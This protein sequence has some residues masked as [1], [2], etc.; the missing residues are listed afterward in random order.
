M[1]EELKKYKEI[2]GHCS[3]PN[4]CSSNKR[5]AKWVREDNWHEMLEDLKEYKE[6]HGDCCVPQGYAPNPALG[7]W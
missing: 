2:H 1:F 3:V 4:K 6:R 5:L 7:R